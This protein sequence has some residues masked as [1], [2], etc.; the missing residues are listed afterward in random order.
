MVNDD[1]DVVRLLIKD[2]Q[3]RADERVSALS[4]QIEC[5]SSAVNNVKDTII[6]RRSQRD[7]EVVE[8]HSKMKTLDNKMEHVHGVINTHNDHY[9]VMAKSMDKLT[10]SNEEMIKFLSTLE[11]IRAM[12]S[13]AKGR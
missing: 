10:A 11:Q 6:E 3:E 12:L 7:A 4:G 13:L 5:L 8:L 2:I 1:K 9:A